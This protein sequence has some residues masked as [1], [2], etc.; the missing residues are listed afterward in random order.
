MV[1]HTAAA[2]LLFC[3]LPALVSSLNAYGHAYSRPNDFTANEYDLI[4]RKFSIFTVEKDHAAS[5]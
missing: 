1:Y 5:L 4:G 3:A 2:A